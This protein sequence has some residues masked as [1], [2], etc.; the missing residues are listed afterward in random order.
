MTDLFTV[1]TP[2]E[3]WLAGLLWA[4]GYLRPSPEPGNDRITLA[5]ADPDVI[6]TVAAIVGPD[7]RIRVQEPRKAT[8]RTCY[9]LDFTDTS[10]ELFRLGMEMKANRRWP[11]ELA[12][13][14]FFRGLFDGDGSVFW[15]QGHTSAKLYL[16]TV[17]CGPAAILEGARDW[18]AGQGV[19]RK[20]ICKH[21]NSWAITWHHADSLRL[22]GIMYA[23]PGPRMARKW[24][25]FRSPGAP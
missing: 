5:Q 18:L 11:A 10:E 3:R 8:H 22:S 6:A 20:K 15:R 14:E 7:H 21:G 13:A 12:S 16:S 4:D 19:T 2:A 24:A 1:W 9:Y 25:R 17:L 23:E